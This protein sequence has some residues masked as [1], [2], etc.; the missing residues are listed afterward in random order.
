MY[1]SVGGEMFDV[2]VNSLAVG[3]RL[4]V[5]GMITGYQDGSAWD[6][7]RDTS[8]TPLAAKLLR[9]SASVTGFFLLHYMSMNS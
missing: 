2:C 1:E 5:I 6:K 3:G 4:I 9:K 8:K 7:Q